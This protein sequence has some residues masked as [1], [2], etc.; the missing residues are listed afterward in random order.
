[1]E[2]NGT[3]PTIIIIIIIVAVV[4]INNSF[5]VGII[6]HFKILQSFSV[7]KTKANF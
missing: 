3:F 1:M 6:Q 4:V 5:F 7:K 2:T